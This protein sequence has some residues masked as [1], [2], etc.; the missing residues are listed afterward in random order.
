TQILPQYC[1]DR[2]AGRHEKW[3]RTFGDA[4]IHMHHYCSGVF[5]EQQAKSIL[6]KREQAYWLGR[7]A[8]QMKYVSG[9]VDTRHVLYPELH[10]RWGWALSEQGQTAE[11][12]K[13]YQL[14]IQAKRNYTLAYARLSDLYLEANKPDEARK[15]LES[16]LKVSPNS[17]SLKRRL[18]KL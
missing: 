16:G 4:F 3:R 10:T 2:A 7:V 17:R 8:H 15:V 12:I 13:H 11:A 14:A 18:K 6:N 5:A 9:S 1:K